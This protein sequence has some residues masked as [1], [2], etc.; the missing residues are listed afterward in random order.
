MKTLGARFVLVGVLV[1]G[2]GCKGLLTDPGPIPAHDPVGPDQVPLW[3]RGRDAA[4]VDDLAEARERERRAAASVDRIDFA[5][6]HA[7]AAA[8]RCDPDA[9]V[10][11]SAEPRHVTIHDPASG[12]SCISDR[13][14]FWCIMPNGDA[15]LVERDTGVRL[16]LPGA[17][18]AGAPDEL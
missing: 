11:T 7:E 3:V 2:A 4:P 17:N 14:G 13:W 6:C 10:V 1:L 15:Y 5:D 16:R 8:I 12:E 9:G 18:D